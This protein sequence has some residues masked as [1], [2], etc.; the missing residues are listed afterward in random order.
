MSPLDLWF[1]TSFCSYLIQVCRFHVFFFYNDFCS[2]LGKPLLFYP[3]WT[4]KLPA[5]TV[6]RKWTLGS[7]RVQMFFFQRDYEGHHDPLNILKP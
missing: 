1:Q 4:S 5:E 3:I 7:W 2:S 6:L